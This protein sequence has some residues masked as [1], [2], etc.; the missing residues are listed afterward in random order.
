MPVVGEVFWVPMD[1][2]GAGVMAGMKYL[3]FG[4][5]RDFWSPYAPMQA[6]GVPV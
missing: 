2:Y 1:K 6:M 5:P 3:S 4:Q